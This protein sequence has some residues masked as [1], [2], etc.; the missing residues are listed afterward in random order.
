MSDRII[1]G[2]VGIAVVAVIIFAIHVT[3]RDSQ[4]CTAHGYD[5]TTRHGVLCV[6]REG[7]LIVPHRVTP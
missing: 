1:A 5:W 7:R 4:W 2:I 3:G 6:D